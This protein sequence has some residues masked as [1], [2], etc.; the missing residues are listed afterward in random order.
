MTGDYYLDVVGKGNKKRQVPIK[1]KVLQ[2]IDQY[3]L[4]RRLHITAASQSEEYLFTTNTLKPFSP[5]YLSQYLTKVIEESNLPFLKHRSSKIG[6]HTFRHSHAII[7]YLSKADLF[8]ISR[9]LGLEKIET[10]TIYLQKVMEREQHEI[11]TWDTSVLGKY[12]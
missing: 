9:S 8:Q 4:A 12:I 1:E 2:S 6:P 10:T 7:S 11:H 3:R 5:S